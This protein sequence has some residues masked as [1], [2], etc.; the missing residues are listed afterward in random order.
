[1]LGD[2][3]LG[4]VTTIRIGRYFSVFIFRNMKVLKV[5]TIRI[6]RI[7]FLVVGFFCWCGG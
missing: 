6:G 4:K 5:T 3:P 7:M 1:M 2:S